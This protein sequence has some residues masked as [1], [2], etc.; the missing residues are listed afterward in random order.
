PSVKMRRP[1][2]CTGNITNGNKSER[3]CQNLVSANKHAPICSPKIDTAGE[4]QAPTQS[5]SGVPLLDRNLEIAENRRTDFA[6]G[7][8]NCVRTIDKKG[9][10]CY[11]EVYLF[12][13]GLSRHLHGLLRAE[14]ARPLLQ[15][16][17]PTYQA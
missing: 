10:N 6:S 11:T 5:P 1:T 13:E 12:R 14:P 17:V 8:K 3:P 4:F 9:C 7:I 15:S 16:P 2:N